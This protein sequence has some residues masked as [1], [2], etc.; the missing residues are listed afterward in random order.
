MLSPF[1]RLDSGPAGPPGPRG[2][3]GATCNRSSRLKGERGPRGATGER[4][5]AAP[6]NRK[7]IVAELTD[8][9]DDIYKQLD[10]Q[11]RR[12]AQIQ[13]QV[14][15]LRAKLRRPDQVPPISDPRGAKVEV[16]Q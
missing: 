3:R 10:I 15:E 5:A 4:G 11:M 9:I 7:V 14:D 16:R 12:M 6:A 2:K 8:H 13:Q 1:V